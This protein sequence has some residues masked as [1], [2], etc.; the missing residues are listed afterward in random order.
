MLVAISFRY[1]IKSTI[2]SQPK[3][4]I[5]FTDNEPHRWSYHPRIRAQSEFF[6]DLV[7]FAKRFA[8][9]RTDKYSLTGR[10]ITEFYFYKRRGPARFTLCKPIRLVFRAC[11]KNHA[12]SRCNYRNV[13]R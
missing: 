6:R 13:N 12:Q 11:S 9:Q 3:Q 4:Q 7:L 8:A 10:R 1:A 5:L 2:Y